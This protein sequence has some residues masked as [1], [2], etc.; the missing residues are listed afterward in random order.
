MKTISAIVLCFSTVLA[1]KGGRCPP[2]GAVFPPPDIPATLELTDVTTQI[3]T[4]IRGNSS[5]WNASTT[6]FS[7]ELTSVNDTLFSIHHTAPIRNE[8]STDRVDTQTIYRVASITKVFTTLLL[9]VHAEG[10]LD[11]P[12]SQF[13]PEL[14]NASHYSSITLRMLASHVAGIP[15][16]SKCPT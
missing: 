15:R 9:L 1:N 13:V 11:S 8:N 5:R 6:S 4:L 3:N 16:D 14:Q 10:H 7:L 2:S 12:V